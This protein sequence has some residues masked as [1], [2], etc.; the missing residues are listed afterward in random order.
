MSTVSFGQ[1]YRRAAPRV[2][3]QSVSPALSLTVALLVIVL[4][5]AFAHGAVS[6]ADGAWLQAAVAASAAL[7]AAACLWRGTLRFA[8]PRGALVAVALLAGFAVWSGISLLWSV[9]PDGTW[10]EFNRDLTYLLVAC[11]ALAAG[12]SDRRTGEVATLGFLLIA[13]LVTA[14][15]LGQKLLPGFHIS[16]LINLNQAGAI[17]RL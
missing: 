11:V 4:Y 7:A 8:A 9:S 6:V 1:L 3:A 12:A 14:Y 15:A 2:T 17:P 5:A 10:S 13:V 16:G